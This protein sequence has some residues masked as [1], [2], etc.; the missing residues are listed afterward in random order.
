MDAANFITRVEDL[1]T[2][3][4]LPGNL[5]G[6][7]SAAP[8][9]AAQNLGTDF[10]TR[11]GPLETLFE[12]PETPAVPAP[13][14][15]HAPTEV[16]GALPAREINNG[17]EPESRSPLISPVYPAEPEPAPVP[18]PVQPF[19]PSKVD[20]DEIDRRTIVVAEQAALAQGARGKIV[21]W[22]IT[23]SRNADG[24]DFRIYDGYN[25]V[26]ANQVCDIVVEDETVSG[27]HAII[28]YREAR[29][30]I[31]DD[32]SRNGTFVNGREITEAY[33]LQNYDQIR[34]GNTH[35][36]YVSAQRSS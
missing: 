19:P 21:G 33:P 29:C 7:L 26:G 9:G 32:L 36:I 17:A 13:E 24:D 12:P 27:S 1:S 31:K 11:V 2:S 6:D 8:A 3:I 35:L 18:S 20:Q 4:D 15:V 28:V 25:R 22:L 34:V 30:L 16:L 10:V 5:L 23:Y 14:P